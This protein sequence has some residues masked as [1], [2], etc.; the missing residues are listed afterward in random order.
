MAAI[1]ARSCWLCWRAV[2]IITFSTPNWNTFCAIDA[3]TNS[4]AFALFNTKDG[5]CVRNYIHVLDLAEAHIKALD[6]IL[7]NKT[8]NL[9]CNLGCDENYTILEIINIIEG[10]ARKHKI[11]IHE[12]MSA[13]TFYNFQIPKTAIPIKIA[14][15]PVK[16][17]IK[18][19]EDEEEQNI[20]II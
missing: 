15:T 5:T 7:D 12:N 18:I 11:S 2:L 10:L 8:D 1:S 19:P 13:K 20:I 6:Y 16:T 14:K 3:S 17:P 4:L 9:I